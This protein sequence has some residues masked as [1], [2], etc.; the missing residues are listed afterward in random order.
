VRCVR[1][2]G[3][4]GATFDVDSDTIAAM[5]HLAPG[6]VVQGY[7]VVRVLS[8]GGVG[9]TFEATREADGERVALKRLA[10]SQVN[11]W[12]RIELFEREA[13]VLAG[14]KN[15]RIPRYLEHFS[16][17][18]AEG[19]VLYIAEQFLDG[20]S[21]A[22][23]GRAGRLPMSE[24]DV[25]R[26]GTELLAVLDYLGRESPPV[27]HRDIKP[28]NVLLRPD[29]SVAL[30]DFGAARSGLGTAEG[31]STTVGT[32]GYMASEQLH[33]VA[34]PATD[35]YGL[36]CTLLFLLTGTSP[37]ELPRRKL[38]IDFEPATRGRITP[39][40]AAWLHKAL[41]PVAED[42]FTSAHSALAALRGLPGGGGPAVDFGPPGARR[43]RV[44]LRSLQVG[45]GR[46]RTAGAS[47]CPSCS[48]HPSRA[49]SRRDGRRFTRPRR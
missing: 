17:E 43:S 40:F 22:D 8:R 34:T 44:L 39:P 33:G 32:Y 37:S 27:I 10:V 48:A 24:A 16:L 45:L 5:T 1:V 35:I 36:A 21:L 19:R 29:G 31:G 11:D 49:R 41:E 2:A 18:S 46:R 3:A 42:R 4:H 28:D 23:L 26:I 15:E 9:T 47:R 12:K 30:V 7:R 20:E 14:L 6:D 13:S 38:K 25:R